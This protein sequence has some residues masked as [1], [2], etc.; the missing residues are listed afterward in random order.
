[1]VQPSGQSRKLA[2]LAQGAPDTL[3]WSGVPSVPVLQVSAL[4]GLP[5]S[6]NW[7]S[8]YTVRS[9]SKTPPAGL[10]RVTVSRPVEN[11]ATGNSTKTSKKESATGMGSALLRESCWIATGT[12]SVSPANGTCT[13]PLTTRTPLVAP[14]SPV[15]AGRVPRGLPSKSTVPSKGSDPGP[16]K[17]GGTG[18][19]SPKPKSMAVGTS[20]AR[21]ERPVRMSPATGATSAHSWPNCIA[22]LLPVSVKGMELPRYHVG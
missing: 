19:K 3:R 6:T 22:R 10:L 5:T 14:S 4:P 15:Q 16:K 9:R 1:M 21:R 7:N 2:S 12:V 13:G 20:E 11:G 17:S 18:G 8:G